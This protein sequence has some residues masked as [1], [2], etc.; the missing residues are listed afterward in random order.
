MPK[1]GFLIL[2]TLDA[3][4]STFLNVFLEGTQKIIDKIWE[5]SLVSYFPSHDTM[6]H[7]S[8][9]PLKNPNQEQNCGF[10]PS[11]EN[12]ASPS[13]P[14]S[15]ASNDVP[16]PLKRDVQCIY[17]R[18][19]V[20]SLPGELCSLRYLFSVISPNKKRQSQKNSPT[21]TVFSL[22]VAPRAILLLLA[23]V[24]HVALASQLDVWTGNPHVTNLL[25]GICP[26]D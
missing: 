1:A 2:R 3:E 22:K 12:V 16:W 4:P 6:L 25:H 24:S 10:H 7:P 13:R 15:V 8:H 11:Q 23:N 17:S 26:T 19:L 20:T 21:L 9:L 14:D 18:C 5:D